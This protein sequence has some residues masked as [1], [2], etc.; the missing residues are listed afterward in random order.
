MVWH[1]PTHGAGYEEMLATAQL[2]ATTAWRRPASESGATPTPGM[3]RYPYG[4]VSPAMDRAQNPYVPLHEPHVVDPWLSYT[5]DRFPQS[6]HLVWRMKAAAS[7][8]PRATTNS[9]PAASQYQALT[10]VKK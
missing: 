7:I 6:G 2:E 1:A 4:H 5:T 3:C 9:G 8:R 10:V